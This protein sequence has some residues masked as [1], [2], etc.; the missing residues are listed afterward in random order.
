[1][2]SFAASPWRQTETEGEFACR[3]LFAGA[4]FRFCLRVE[5]EQAEQKRVDL[6]LRHGPTIDFKFVR[7]FS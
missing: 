2:F 5:E 7:R 1:M 6:G 4:R 3:L